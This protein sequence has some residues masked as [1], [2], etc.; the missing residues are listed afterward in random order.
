MEKRFEPIPDAG[1]T[2]RSA[3]SGRLSTLFGLALAALAE[4]SADELDLVASDE[5]PPAVGRWRA[6]GKANRDEDVGECSTDATPG[7]GDDVATAAWAG[8]AA[9]VVVV[10]DLAP[11]PEAEGFLLM[12]GEA[13]LEPVEGTN[14]GLAG[15]S[16]VDVDDVGNLG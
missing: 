1:G 13:W 10:D 2:V 15:L 14:S 3:P 4:A 11:E 16:A 5:E 6:S 9:D 8:S 12:T 7:G